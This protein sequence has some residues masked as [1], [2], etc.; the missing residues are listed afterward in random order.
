MTEGSAVLCWKG[1]IPQGIRPKKECIKPCE[2]CFANTH[3]L[4]DKGPSLTWVCF[5]KSHTPLANWPWLRISP[6]S[7]LYV[8]YCLTLTAWQW[9]MSFTCLPVQNEPNKSPWR[10][11]LP[12]LLLWEISHLSSPS[13]SCLGRF[14]LISGGR[15]LCGKAPPT[16]CNR[17]KCMAPSNGLLSLLPSVNYDLSVTVFEVVW[18]SKWKPPFATYYP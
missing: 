10:K 4:N 7:S 6:Q 11:R 12:A 1:Q 14:I 16:F 13:R 15:G 18:I 17:S 9:L 2:T 3:S 5:P 8:I